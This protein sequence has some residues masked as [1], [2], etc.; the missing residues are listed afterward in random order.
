MI[1]FPILFPVMIPRESVSLEDRV[2]QL[3]E[4]L[5]LSIEMLQSVVERIE[6]MFGND[7]LGTDLRHLSADT[8]DADGQRVLD[9]IERSLTAGDKS[10]AGGQ[11]RDAFGCTWDQA[12]EAIR[13]WRK[14]SREKK[15]RWFR[16]AR[17]VK[18][19]DIAKPK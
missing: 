17:Y 11:F 16:L 18:S 8:S 1:P 14:H 9:D 3:E 19:L 5:V 2:C 7:F 13:H 10:T 4:A 6:S 15:L 12:H